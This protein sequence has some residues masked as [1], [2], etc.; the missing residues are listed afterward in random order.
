MKTVQ[1]LLIMMFALGFS[2]TVE[3]KDFVL[4]G[5]VIDSSNGQPI[6]YASILISESGLWAIT[7]NKGTF[8][9]RHVKAGKTTLTVQCLGYRKKTWPMTIRRNVLDLTLRIQQETLKLEGVTSVWY[10]FSCIVPRINLTLVF[11]QLPVIPILIRS[12]LD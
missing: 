8:T 3:A 10:F 2:M 11:P 4:S 1:T 6:E 9:I 5:K 7:D 12:F